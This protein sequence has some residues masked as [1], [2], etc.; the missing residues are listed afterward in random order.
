ML[1]INRQENKQLKL[2]NISVCYAMA[3]PQYLFQLEKL[4]RGTVFWLSKGVWF[5]MSDNYKESQ[6]I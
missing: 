4:R 3:K 2:L 5:A 6:F 1:I